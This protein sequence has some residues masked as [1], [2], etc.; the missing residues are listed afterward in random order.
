MRAV[1]AGV[2]IALCACATASSTLSSNGPTQQVRVATPMGET[3]L[4]MA[5]TTDANVAQLSA[6][7]DRVWGQLPAAYDSLGIP[8]NTANSSS[9]L[10]GNNGLKLRHQL[11]KVYLSKYI[12]CGQTQI[13][14]NADSY[15]VMLTVYTQLQAGT[16]GVGST[17]ISTTV[18]AAARPAAFAQ[19]YARCSSK[20]VLESK[21]VDLLKARAH[22]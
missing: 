20:G 8:V 13:G 4:A 5:S 15:D 7:I 2:A 17:Q 22:Q 19:A 18:D 6:P 16:G 10:I 21:L 11:G 9:H 3:N 1:I 12:D 14:E